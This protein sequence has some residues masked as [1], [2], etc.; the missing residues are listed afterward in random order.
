LAKGA[1]QRDD[2]TGMVFAGFLL[3]LDPPKAD[4][5][6]VLGDLA[7][8]HV[9]VKVITGD[10]RFVT[11]HLAETVGLDPTSMLTGDALAKLSDEALWHAAPRLHS[12]PRSIRSR[13]SVSC[14]RFSARV[15]RSATSATGS[16]TPPRCTRPTSASR[17]IRPW[18]SPA[19]AP[20]SSS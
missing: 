11:G 16:T 18:T 5:A 20:T 19:R 17:S 6:R 2:E 13:K 12:S 1:Y 3:F 7:K 14:A 4:A 10:N 8:L 15:T 9:D